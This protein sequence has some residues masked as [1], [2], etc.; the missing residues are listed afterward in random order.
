MKH[1]DD[2]TLALVNRAREGDED[3][4]ERLFAISYERLRLYVRMRLG[5]ALRGKLE[6]DD[7][8]QDTYV[9]AHEA[10]ASFRWH[11]PTS[12]SRWLCRIAE[13]RIRGLVDFHAA[14]KR[15]P[16]E[17]LARVSRILERV[18]D[19]AGG[20]AS[21]VA[22]S[23]ETTRLVGALDAMDDEPREL[24]MLRFYA[25]MSYDEIAALTGHSRTTIRRRIARASRAL[26]TALG[27]AA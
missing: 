21:R 17:G 7:V 25:G 24:L 5:R 18:E 11:G 20:P 9:L 4:Y 19:S 1:D 15:T 13:N 12:F 26:S 23:E 27:S 2:R 6:S 10:F 8:L 14:A 22:R 16:P 3:A